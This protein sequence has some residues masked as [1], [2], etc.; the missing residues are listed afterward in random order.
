MVCS[1]TIKAALIVGAVGFFIYR[2]M[3]KK[4]SIKPKPEAYKKDYKK[5]TVYLY[6]FKRTRKCPNL[7]PFCIKVEILCRAYNIPYEI[8]DDKLRWSRNGSI[9]FIELNGEHIADTDLIEM[10][11]RRHFNIPSLPAAQEAHSVALTRLADNH[12]FN[13]LI[14]YKIIGDEFFHI[15]VRSIG[16]PKFLQP[17]LF[18]LIRASFGKKVYQRSTGSIGD[19]ELKEMDDILHRDFQTIQD[20]LG[21][22]KFLFGD[23]VTAADAAVFG[24]IASVIYPFRCSINDALENDFPKILEY[25]ERVRQEIYPNDFTI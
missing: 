20:Y 9:P 22:Q 7:S 16:I 17:L 5:D 2:K 25:C 12:L 14:R 11:L 24:Q 13:L 6:Q 23:K 8:C 4:P 10:R 3:F 21:D 18:P 19:F 1:C 15:L